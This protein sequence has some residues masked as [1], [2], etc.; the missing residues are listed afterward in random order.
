MDWQRRAGRFSVL[1]VASVTLCSVGC[2]NAN[3][4]TTP[5]GGTD[6]PDASVAA[7]LVVADAG[8][9][10]VTPVDAGTAPVSQTPAP[11]DDPDDP[12]CGGADVDLVAVLANRR[13]HTRAD[14]PAS[15]EGWAQ[16]VKMKLLAAP[17]KVAPGGKVELMLELENTGKIAVPLY[18]AGDLTLSPLVVDSKGARITP[19]AG[20]APK[21]PDPRCAKEVGCKN[22]TSHVVLAAGGKAHAKLTWEA[23]KAAWPKTGPTACCTIHVDPVYTAPLAAGTYKVKLPLPFETPQGAPADPEISLKIA[24]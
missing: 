23:K 6:V 4:T 11:S 21:S 12:A 24:K 2:G 7:P 10:A 18:F 14:A 15:P 17:E 16:L 1:F 9:V 20:P 22:P 3:T 5:S 13:C 8:A 19:P